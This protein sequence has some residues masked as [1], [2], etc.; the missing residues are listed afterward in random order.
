MTN[1]S[2]S[3]SKSSNFQNLH[4][5]SP[6]SKLL[7][8]V[9]ISKS[10]NFDFTSKKMFYSSLK[11]ILREQTINAL[12]P[13]KI[14]S[15][16]SRGPSSRR[17]CRFSLLKSSLFLLLRLLCLGVQVGS[18][19]SNCCTDLGLHRQSISEKYNTCSNNHNTLNHVTYSV[20][21][22]T[23]TLQSIKGKLIIQVIKKTNKKE[24]CVES[25]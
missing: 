7:C 12:N 5:K 16:S 13:P 25:L 3:I 4:T 9:T 14:S 18:Q 20:R 21:N 17:W 24:R 6:I 15:G 10:K 1:S 19:N 23:Y 2:L 22:R 8:P 11:T